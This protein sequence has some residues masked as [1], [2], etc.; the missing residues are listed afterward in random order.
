MD[1]FIQQNRAKLQEKVG[2]LPV[3]L[4]EQFANNPKTEVACVLSVQPRNLQEIKNVLS[5]CSEL[6]LK[7]RCSGRGYSWS[8]IFSDPGQ[9]LLYTGFFNSELGKERIRLH[10]VFLSDINGVE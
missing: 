6:G 2:A 7:V 3:V 8:P 9:V 4:I 5:A 10:K 1:E